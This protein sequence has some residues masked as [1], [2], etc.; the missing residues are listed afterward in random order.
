MNNI[1]SRIL[2]KRGIKDVTELTKEEQ[3]D[4]GNWQTILNK[5]EI[6][7]K[8][9]TKLCDSVIGAIENQ[10]GDIELSNEKI[11]KLTLQHSI[12]K[13]IRNLMNAPRAERESLVEYLTSLL[14]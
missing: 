11:A 10:F 8:D 7:V 12:Y 1:L 3:V 5:E 6:T 2:Q 13:K 14:K 9:I 4:F